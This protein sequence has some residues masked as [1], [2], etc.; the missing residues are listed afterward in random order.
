MAPIKHPY[1][2]YIKYSV[3]EDILSPEIEH[4]EQML[5][6]ISHS[7]LFLLSFDC[8]SNLKAAMQR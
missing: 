2:L 6:T 1:D 3:E 8:F 5:K 4:I 7:S